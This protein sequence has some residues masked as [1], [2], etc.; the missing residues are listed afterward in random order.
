MIAE[1]GNED[2]HS[3]P[4][5]APPGDPIP[6]AV[7]AQIASGGEAALMPKMV[8]KGNLPTKLCAACDLPFAWRKKWAR[9]WDQVKFCS[10]RC[11]SNA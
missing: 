9:D 2:A 7:L 11:R 8:K 1:D 3:A 5:N 10:D 6:R 4:D